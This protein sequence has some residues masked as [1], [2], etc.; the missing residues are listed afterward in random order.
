MSNKITGHLKAPVI[1]I[2]ANLHPFWDTLSKCRNQND[3]PVFQILGCFAL[4]KKNVNGKAAEARKNDEST[5]IPKDA[6]PAA[7]DI[8]LQKD[9]PNKIQYVDCGIRTIK[10]PF[11]HFSTPIVCLF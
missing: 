9:I 5:Y 7:W 1:L 11:C 6:V 3:A 8:T 4:L 2:T 10:T